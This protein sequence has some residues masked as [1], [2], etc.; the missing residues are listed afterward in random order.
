MAFQIALHDL[1]KNLSRP[2][3]HFWQRAEGECCGL[4][5]RPTFLVLL[6][7]AF[8]SPLD[9][10]VA[11]G[12]GVLGLLCGLLTAAVSAMLGLVYDASI[13]VYA[14]LG[15]DA[16]SL[17]PLGQRLGLCF[18]EPVFAFDICSSRPFPPQ[19][20]Q[21]ALA[22]S[23]CG[24]FLFSASRRRFRKTGSLPLKNG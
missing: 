3:T 9:A 13:G 20:A 24:L 12:G 15:N 23:A 5:I 6:G 16:N 19:W 11:A 1:K 2:V 7:F 4:R 10:R 22:F 14:L 18:E 21:A 17:L 8:Y